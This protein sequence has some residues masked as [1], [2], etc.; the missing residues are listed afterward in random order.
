MV[1]CTVNGLVGF[2]NSEFGIPEFRVWDSRIHRMG[3][4]RTGLGFPNP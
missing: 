4:S 2:P 3:K 1:V